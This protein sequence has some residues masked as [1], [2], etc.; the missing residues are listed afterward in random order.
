MIAIEYACS[1]I[2][3][4]LAREVE[5]GSVFRVRPRTYPS[6]SRFLVNLLCKHDQ[7]AVRPGTKIGPTH[8][9]TPVGLKII[10]GISCPGKAC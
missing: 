6:T 1:S 2:I 9:F 4:S 5:Y 7:H 8:I 10:Q 3:L